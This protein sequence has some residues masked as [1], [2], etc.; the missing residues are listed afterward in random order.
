MNYE[1]IDLEKRR[2]DNLNPIQKVLFPH[3]SEAI[4]ALSK[5]FTFRDSQGKGGL[6]VL[7]T[8][9]GK[10]FTAV[11]W[12]S[13]IAIHKGAKILWLAHSFHLLDQACEEFDKNAKWIPFPKSSLNIRV[14]SSNPSHSRA[15]DIQA[16]DDVVIMTTPTAIGCL[17]DPS[18]DKAGRVVDSGLTKF[19]RGIKDQRLVLVLDEAHHAPA[20][21]CRRLL[22]AI[23]EMHPSAYYLGL[24]ATPGY[25]DETR[26]GW[27]NKLFD[28][29]IIYE[30]NKNKL[31]SQN[32]LAREKLIQKKT[33]EVL[34]VDDALYNRLMREHRDLPEDIV[35]KLANNSLR[36]DFII[37]EYLENRAEYGKTI[38]FADRWFQCVYLK[39]KLAKAGVRVD[40][41]YSR[42][43]ADPGSAEARNRRTAND[44]Q[45]II[46]RFKD[47]DIDV[48]I[49]VRMLTEGTDAPK[50]KTVFITRETTSSILLTQMIGRALRGEKAGGGPGKKDA[51]IVFFTDTWRKIIQWASYSA[52]G[53]VSEDQSVRGYYP[54]EMIS[55][56]LVE[57]L[58]Q[59]I[60]SGRSFQAEAFSE[61][62]PIGWYQATYSSTGNGE[63]ID[64]FDEF[65]MV[66][67]FQEKGFKT[68]IQRNL[69]KLAE[70]WGK[71]DLA[72][73][74]ARKE[75]R[76]LADGCFDLDK[77]SLGETLTDDLI[78][79]ARHMA[80]NS[81]APKYFP[82]EERDRYDLD[83][84]ATDL[85]LKNSLDQ[86]CAL[87]NIFRQSG[88][89]WPSFYRTFD[90]F[91]T[92][93]D[94]A[95][96]RLMVIMTTGADSNIKLPDSVSLPDVGRIRELPENDK[97]LVFTRDNFRCL[98]CGAEKSRA[99]KLQVDHIL[100]DRMGGETSVNNSQT[101]CK[102]CNTTKGINELMFRSQSTTLSAPKKVF[103]IF[104]PTSYDDFQTFT[105]RA[106]NFFYHCGAVAGCR[107]QKDAESG[108][109]AVIIQ[110]YPGNDPLW[111]KPHCNRLLASIR[112]EFNR[113]KS[114]D[115]V[116][117]E[118]NGERISEEFRQEVEVEQEE[119]ISPVAIDSDVLAKAEAGNANAQVQIGLRYSES[120]N[121]KD[122]EK[123]YHWF[124]AAASLGDPKGH[125]YLAN[126]LLEDGQTLKE[127]K[128]ARE[129][130]KVAAEKGDAEAQYLLSDMIDSEL[131]G[132]KD[133]EEYL[134]WLRLAALQNQPDA[135]NNLGAA[136]HRGEG[137]PQDYSQ[138]M[139]HY[140]KAADLGLGLAMR[141]IGTLY[142]FG[143]GVGVDVETAVKW[144][145]KA[146]A[147]GDS[148]ACRLLACLFA[149]GN[150]VQKNL[151]EAYLLYSL[152]ALLAEE[153]R[154]RGTITASRT[155]L[156]KTMTQEEVFQAEEAIRDPNF[157]EKKKASLGEI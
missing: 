29:W 103:E 153:G 156:A 60:N 143:W 131:G 109:K 110:L 112:V 144:Y 1:S 37:Q 141:N 130:F 69:G 123:A 107:Q 39:D 95:I 89:L 70:E 111:L 96:N 118:A 32:I 92:A 74:W 80:R 4:E 134:K 84:L 58:V 97:Q 86:R 98:C 99:V 35:E 105:R 73:D 43:D 2:N 41:V 50:T 78:R 133:P 117:V 102:F 101:L 116:V 93:F 152:A 76:R 108:R 23:R 65:V 140:R 137:V 88:S 5:T 132:K 142:E 100:P 42:I 139:K 51:N 62:M 31:Q 106:V 148:Y 26:R 125:R 136:F 82:F 87:E 33:N 34:E 48:L 56:R 53:G 54:T 119:N 121:P 67:N 155:K 129:H 11:K 20:Y 17:F 135:V 14:V 25:S 83:K 9:A 30:A 44:N 28:Q 146:A 49:N 81:A 46:K 147:K 10:T 52:G 36:N 6:L 57:E 7:P 19:L 8:G 151:V 72:M 77:D 45:K 13:E 145:Q 113:C 126:C 59:R 27:L 79:M 154:E 12:L 104:G 47:G 127:F 66:Y 22:S 21:G 64:T 61:L 91:K 18:L 40:T 157:I 71:E 115:A 94:G 85:H 149:K 38:I 15:A 128:R 124:E 63:E 68:F 16:T 114:I 122:R 120:Q 55:I 75:I 24:T 3:Q 150:G 138:A 90:R